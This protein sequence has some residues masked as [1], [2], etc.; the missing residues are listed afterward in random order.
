MNIL[1]S[2]VGFILAIGILVVV[3]EF[4]HYWV[5]RKLGVKV[6]RFSVGF[7]RPVWV[8]R[9]GPDQ[10]EYVLSALPLG[11]Y[12]KMLDENDGGVAPEEHHRA[13]NR[14]SVPRRMAIAFAGPAFNFIFAILAYA[15]VFMVGIDGLKPIVGKVTPDSIAARAGFAAGDEI[16]AVDGE[17]NQTWD[18]HRLY[19]YER[20]L[21]GEGVHMTV[22]TTAGELVDREL[23]LSGLRARD[24]DE[25]LLERSIG[26]FGYMP[27][28]APVLGEIEADSAAANA[29]LKSGDRVLAV[30]GAPVA[31]WAELVA[32]IQAAP[33]QI[34]TLAIERG[35]TPQ[36]VKVVPVAHEQGG[37]TVG[38][39][40][41]GPH[42][43]ELPPEWRTQLRL[44][45]LDAL[46]KGVSDS[47]SMSVLMLKMLWKMLTLEV[48]TKNIS[49]PI[50]IAQYAGFSV[51]IGLD[52]F[53]MFLAVVSISL[54]V[55]NL[56]PIPILDGGHLLF[57]AIEGIK[58]SPVS[59]RM[60][61]MGQ[62]LGMAVLLSLM[63]LAFY[64]DFVRVLQ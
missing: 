16:V 54:G 9:A 47:W 43:P 38:R 26:L 28:L 61:G 4:G 58:G 8:K 55:L 18:Q 22:K 60:V 31:T 3:H 24:V 37:R 48:S 5:A 36:T 41:A 21:D 46:A 42:L 35:D 12:V 52:R 27:E 29:G 20:A 10:T 59:D 17:P 44:G 14:Q 45:P 6:L 49:G 62:R 25:G 39:I 30:N 19:I 13:F 33:K 11:G 2:V 32:K 7:G 15:I 64:N 23:D 40:G 57:Y 50:T 1:Y 63:V 51:Q 34:L 53:L 56:L